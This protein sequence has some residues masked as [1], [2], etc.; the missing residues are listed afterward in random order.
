MGETPLARAFFAGG[1]AELVAATFDA[2]GAGVAEEDVAFVVGALTFLGRLGDAE[3]CFDAWR[4]RARAPEPRT[5][6]ASR[7][8]LG[9]A[10][11]RAGDFGRARSLLVAGALARVAEDD[12]WTVA[13]AF[14]G[15]AA[16]RYFTGR[17]RAAGRH[18]LRALRAAHAARFPWVRMLSTDLRGHALVQL[19]RLEAG[20]SLLEQA[21]AEAE[22]L[23]LG[24]NVLAIE[25]SIA[26]YRARFKVGPEALAGLARPSRGALPIRGDELEVLLGRRAH[27]S[28]SRRTLL[29]Q[30]VV[31]YALRGRGAEAAR[32]LAEVDRDALRMDA[33]RAKV[34]SLLA[35]LHATR[36]SQGPR[37]CL[38]LLDEAS[39]ELDERDLAF[40]AE[41]LVFE[42]HVAEATGDAARAARA[43]AE[44]RAVGRRT[45]QYL[46][47][48]V[49][50]RWASPEDELTPLLRSASAPDAELPRLLALGLLGPVPERLGVPPGRAVLLLAA[51]N[52]IVLQD[53]GD[54]W[55]RA[56]PPRWAP[57]LLRLLAG[58]SSKEAIV[59][60]LWGLR[61]YAP[62]RHDP[63]IRTTIHRLRALLQPRGHWVT[64]TEEGYGLAVPVHAFGAPVDGE[65]AELPAEDAGE[66]ELFAPPPRRARAAAPVDERDL[67][68]LGQLARLGEATVPALA[69]ALAVSESTAL[70]ALRRLVRAKRVRR[71]G[72]ARATRYALAG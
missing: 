42:A 60:G 7:F 61:R 19:G 55:A 24:S 37:A 29:A 45:D 12:P 65:L 20:T 38:A 11:A 56:S 70:R 52:A 17:F 21:K 32:A 16:F 49:D 54:L 50:E 64:V 18:A 6:A 1:Y 2:P 47:R 14:Q 26:V 9:V 41:L 43:R 63:L 3:A 35:R 33:R 53:G 10:L 22:R 46:A 40:R 66:D 71:T 51:E 48:A 62:A 44:L 67:P 23:G 58:G 13:F 27:D 5:L 28:Y 25:A 4:L 39:T 8:F 30:A 59:A 72:S 69:R 68:V 57:A 34:T 15:L 31:Q 36:W